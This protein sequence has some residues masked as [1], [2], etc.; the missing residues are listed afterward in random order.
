M[1]DVALVWSQALPTLKHGVTGVGVWAALNA[2]KPLAVE[3]GF[4]VLGLDA[5][6]FELAGH[7]RIPATKKLIESEVGRRLNEAVHLRVIEGTTLEHWERNKRRDE[8]ARRM[9]DVALERQRAELSARTNWES[10]YE[11]LSRRYAAVSNKSIPMNRARFFEEA[12]SI[13]VEARQG[14]ASHDDLSERNFARCI[15][16]VAQYSEVPSTLVAHFVLRA[17]GEL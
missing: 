2:A 7:L 1:A 9:Q 6:E 8:E 16:R 5:Q 17:A 4:L 12:I 15:E 3:N 14:Q 10:V 11:S 13:L